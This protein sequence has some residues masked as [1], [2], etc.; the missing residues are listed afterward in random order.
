MKVEPWDAARHF[1][2][3]RKWMNFY[4]EFPSGPEFMPPSGFVVEGLAMCFLIRTDARV[5]L[6]EG[7]L[8]NP[9]LPRAQVDPALDAVAAAVISLARAEGFRV[10][11][12]TTQVEAVVERAKRLGFRVDPSRYQMLALTLG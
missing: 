6:I 5:A 10:L 11:Q 3:Y 8:G 9:W 2:S 4:D 1:E 12:A 7:L